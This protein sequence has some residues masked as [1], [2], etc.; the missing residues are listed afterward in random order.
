M[1]IPAEKSPNPN[2]NWW[3]QLQPYQ[4]LVFIVA[5]LAWLFDC[6]DQQ[7]F[8]LARKPAMDALLGAKQDM[9]L[10]GKFPIQAGALSTSIFVLGW[11][12]GGMIFGSLGDRYGRAKM[13]SV[14]VL[15]YSIATGLSALSQSFTDFAVYRFI[16]GLGVGGVFGL[17][18]ALVAD[19]VPGHVRPRALGVLQ[20]FSAVGNCAAGFIG[21][22]IAL[23]ALGDNDNY[24]KWLFVIGALP[25]FLVA[26]IQLRMKEP[27]SWTQSRD[28][29]KAEGKRSGSY[30]DLFGHSLWL[31]H[32]LL[33]MVLSC[34]GVIGLW[35]IGVFSS[36]LVGDIISHN[37][38][39]AGAKPEEISKGKQLWM[40]LNLLAFNAGAFAG[41]LI[42][43]RVAVALGRKKAFAVFFTGAL[44]V[45]VFVFQM[46]GKINGRWDILWMAPLMGFFQLSVFAGFSIY[47]PELFP[48]RLR[49]TG[50][51]FCYNV[52]RYFAALGPFTLG[53]LAAGFGK[54]AD[55][56]LGALKSVAK[57]DAF[58]DAA[59]W[60]CLIFLIG[61]IVLPFLPETK[62]KPLPED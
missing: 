57:I 44:L 16:T 61:I 60:M 39:E 45:T 23:T 5:T 9:M 52:G 25:A 62:G 24:W 50:V 29:A 56:A 58:R 43:T 27:E 35:G 53:A 3:S 54:K 12:T 10:F 8:N 49:A 46:I 40:S 18:V 33:G 34:A 21:L 1:S 17:A 19:T 14:T 20:S 38:L 13:L 51:S 32:A 55:A 2:D 48:T 26:T 47:L 22:T 28:K 30:R 59:S 36:D 41:M 31:K 11:A 4:R 7:L 42:F 6:L 15:L 37:L